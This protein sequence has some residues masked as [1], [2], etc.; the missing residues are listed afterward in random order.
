MNFNN[1]INWSNGQPITEIKH[2]LLLYNYGR[3]LTN[4]QF[5]EELNPDERT[6]NKLLNRFVENGLMTTKKLHGAT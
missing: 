6:T 2:N 1:Q 3:N 4:R 5:A